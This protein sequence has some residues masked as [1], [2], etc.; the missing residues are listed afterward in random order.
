MAKDI[1]TVGPVLSFRGIVDGRWRVTALIG[2][3]V[4]ASAPDL[5]IEGRACAAPA[6]LLG[7]LLAL[8]HRSIKRLS[9]M[10]M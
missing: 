10:S 9:L 8:L 3:T 6:L 2:V 5:E 1:F 4:D 7:Y